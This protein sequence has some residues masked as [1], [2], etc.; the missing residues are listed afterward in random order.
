MTPSVLLTLLSPVVAIAI[1]TWGFR[2]SSKADRLRAFFELHERYLA[3]DVRAGRRTIHQSIAGRSPGEVA[4]LDRQSLS[5]AG[6]ALAT[7]NSIA[8][9]CEG[10]YVDRELINRSMGRSFRNVINAA[11]PYIDH[12]ESVR[13]YRPY[14]F[15]ERLAAALG[16]GGH[17]AGPAE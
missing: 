13:G 12:V 10:R 1:A 15:A 2:R 5:S 7:M 3:S 16:A 6:Y 14:P 11:K 9:A 17:D 8:I 4:A